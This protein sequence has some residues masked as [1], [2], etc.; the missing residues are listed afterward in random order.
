MQLQIRLDR[1]HLNSSLRYE[2]LKTE[3]KA[4]IKVF[5]LIIQACSDC[6]K[7]F[8]AYV[9]FFLSVLFLLL[10]QMP[11]WS[12]CLLSVFWQSR[13]AVFSRG[14]ASCLSA[15]LLWFALVFFILSMCD[16]MM[17][18]LNV[19]AA[20]ERACQRF[21]LLF[22]CFR[23]PLQEQRLKKWRRASWGK[24]MLLHR[25]PDSLKDCVALAAAKWQ[26]TRDCATV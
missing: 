5:Q 14:T 21:S 10:R 8:E 1:M 19:N 6:C 20:S 4:K 16:G 9:V 25:G 18:C 12:C 11:D 3:A 2:R 24:S 15:L 7:L 17:C 23:T 13:A 22:S 26:Q